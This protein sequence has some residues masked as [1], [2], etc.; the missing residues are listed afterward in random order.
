MANAL[1]LTVLLFAGTVQIILSLFM[2]NIYQVS[3]LEKDYFRQG[4]RKSE[5][6]R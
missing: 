2:Q 5:R 6:S 4:G 1:S 3:T